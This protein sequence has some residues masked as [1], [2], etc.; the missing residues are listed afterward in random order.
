MTGSEKKCIAYIGSNTQSLKA[1]RVLSGEA[2]LSYVVK[3]SSSGSR[4]GCGYGVSFA[5]RNKYNVELIL[6]KNNIPIKEML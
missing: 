1:Q 4:K 5:C 3:V 2:I 6:S